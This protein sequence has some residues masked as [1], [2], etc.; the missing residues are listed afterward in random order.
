MTALGSWVNK[1]APV[2]LAYRTGDIPQKRG[3]EQ[4]S[5]SMSYAQPTLIRPAPTASR[6]RP[7]GLLTPYRTG[8][9]LEKEGGPGVWSGVKIFFGGSMVLPILLFVLFAACTAI[10]GSGS[11]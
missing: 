5:G 3:P 4:R 9:M 7:P 1:A 10:A 6:L 2:T 11:G 8:A